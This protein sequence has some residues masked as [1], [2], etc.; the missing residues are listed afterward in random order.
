M[1][2]FL[3]YDDIRRKKAIN[4]LLN[5][6]YEQIIFFTCQSMEK[7]ILDFI[8]ADYQYIKI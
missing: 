4:L 2:T 3:E 7:S 1:N 6:G 5:E 8:D